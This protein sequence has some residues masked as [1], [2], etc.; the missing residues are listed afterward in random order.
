VGTSVA[1]ALLL[2]VN[3]TVSNFFIKEI[4]I[5][6]ITASSTTAAFT[7]ELVRTDGLPLILLPSGFILKAAVTVTQ[8]HALV[9]TAY[10]GAY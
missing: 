5:S 9:I 2:F 10:G 7:A 1:G 3:D 8:T 4:A 6:A